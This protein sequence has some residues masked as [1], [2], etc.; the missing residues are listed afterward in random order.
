MWFIKG[1]QPVRNN[2]AEGLISL[3]SDRGPRTDIMLVV[4]EIH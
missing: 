1:K 2:E 4:A 3:V